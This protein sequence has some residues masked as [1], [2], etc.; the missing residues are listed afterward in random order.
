LIG[1]EK[2]TDGQTNRQTDL[3]TCAKQYAFFFCEGGMKI[4]Y[5]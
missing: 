3:P 4:F 2:V 1:N 5:D